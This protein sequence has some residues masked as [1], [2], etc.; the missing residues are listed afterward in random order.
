MDF[1]MV[2]GIWFIIFMAMFP[3]I[4]MV[5]TG[6]FSMCFGPWFFLGWLLVPR[7]T[8]A[9]LASICYWDTNSFLVILTWI[10]S[11]GGESM[12]KKS[13]KIVIDK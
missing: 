2:H 12:E 11:M 5:L 1:W 7:L 4:T 6:I 10:W 9:I 13:I 8:V 3:R